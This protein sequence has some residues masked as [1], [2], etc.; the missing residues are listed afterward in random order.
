MKKNIAFFVLIFIFGNS[1]ADLEVSH[2]VGIGAK[3]YGM[4]NNFVAVSNDQSALFYNPAGLAFVP[5]REFQISIDGLSQKSISEFNNSKDYSFP[6]QRPRMANIGYM[7]AFPTVQGG[8]TMSG[9]LLCPVIFD[10]SRKFTGT[11]LDK[12]NN[13]IRVSRELRSFGGLNYWDGGFGLQIAKGLGVGVSGAFVSGKE[14]GHTVFYQDTNGRIGDPYNDDYD[15]YYIRN[16]LGYDI[17]LG[18]MYNFSEH[19]A[20][21]LRVNI[22]QTLWFSEEVSETYPHSPLEPEYISESRG[23]LISSYSGAAGFSCMFPFLTASCEFRIR[24]PYSFVA[25]AENIPIESDAAKVKIGAG[26]GIEI[27]LILS[28]TLLR[29]GYSWDQYDTYPFARKYSD[30]KN[31]YFDSEAKSAF[32]DSHLLTAGLGF[33]IKNVCLETAYGYNFWSL[34][35]RGTLKENYNQQRLIV[36]FSIRF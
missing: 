25:P 15:Q 10:E 12:S 19:Y 36:T 21:G 32:I 20:I 16:Y 22:P 27:P 1:F 13:V 8:F 5:A 31:I 11:Y 3:S 7:H 4:A 18:L 33:I 30:E 29:F 26:A 34:D 23:K 9:A 28:T 2:T 14:E 17:R 6:I 24:A 35:T